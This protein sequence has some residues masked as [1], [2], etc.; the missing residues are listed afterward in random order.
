MERRGTHTLLSHPKQGAIRAQGK[1]ER[2]GGDG[3][4]V[5]INNSSTWDGDNQGGVRMRQANEGGGR[6]RL[7]GRYKSEAAPQRTVQ[8]TQAEWDE[9]E[10]NTRRV[11]G[12]LGEEREEEGWGMEG[13]DGNKGGNLQGGEPVGVNWEQ[14]ATGQK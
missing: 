8:F 4:Q 13:E 6:M 9:G 3:F 12:G 2:G 10:D 1:T 14:E 5:T 7:G 11:I